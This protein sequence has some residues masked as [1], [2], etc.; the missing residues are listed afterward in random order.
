VF[1]RVK[2]LST[3]GRPP[4][5]VLSPSNWSPKKR[6]SVL[7]LL[8]SGVITIA[9]IVAYTNV[10][11]STV[12]IKS[13]PPSFPNQRLDAPGSCVCHEM[14][15]QNYY[16]LLETVIITP[17]LELSGSRDDREFHVTPS[18]SRCNSS[19][20]KFDFFHCLQYPLDCTYTH[21]IVSRSGK[22]RGSLHGE[23]IDRS[24]RAEQAR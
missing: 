23:R 5:L 15:P 19:A 20:E 16:S 11:R 3:R 21:P 8:D 10:P 1:D 6:Q 13:A 18:A 4:T 7:S 24:S 22:P 12:Y 14:T 17:Y 9:E 2:Y